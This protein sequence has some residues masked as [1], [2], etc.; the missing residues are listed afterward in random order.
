MKERF[1]KMLWY[2]VT[3]VAIFYFTPILCAL[4]NFPLYNLLPVFYLCAV[5]IIS[6]MF[7]KRHGGDWLISLVSMIAFIPCMYMFFNETAWIYVPIYGIM[8]FL[9]VILGTIFKNRFLK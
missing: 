4:I 9:C 3:I 1:D 2:V 7:A 8:S 5:M 6:F